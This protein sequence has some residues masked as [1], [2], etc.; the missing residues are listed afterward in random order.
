MIRRVPGY[1]QIPIVSKT[2]HD[3]D[4]EIFHQVTIGCEDEFVLD[5]WN[6]PCH[7]VRVKGGIYAENYD[8]RECRIDRLQA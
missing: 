4:L 1:R 2:C 3:A 5:R 7:S 6:A 8:T